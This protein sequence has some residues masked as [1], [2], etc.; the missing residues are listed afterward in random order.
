MILLNNKDVLITRFPD[1]SFKYDLPE[2][3]IVEGENYIVWKFESMEELFTLMSIKNE[4]DEAQVTCRLVLP[5]LPNARMDK[6]CNPNEGLM[7]KHLVMSLDNLGFEQIELL[8]PHSPAYKQWAK[9]TLW[10]ENDELLQSIID[11]VITECM[12]D[13]VNDEITMKDVTL[14]FPDKGAKQRYSELLD[15]GDKNIVYGEK[16]RNQETG[17][18]LS[19]DLVGNVENEKVLIIDDI[20]SKGGTF[21]YTAKKLRENGF[22]G[23]IFLYITHCEDTIFDGELLKEDSEIKSVFSTNSLINS[24]SDRDSQSSIV[25]REIQVMEIT[26]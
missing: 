14:V 2:N 3:A 6:V 20:C 21:F 4:L 24:K 7:L 1:N 18:I 13:V 19:F 9:N 17:E 8:D 22:Q 16:V 5:Y 23:D 12:I 15:I 10:L 26:F 25:D 11:Y